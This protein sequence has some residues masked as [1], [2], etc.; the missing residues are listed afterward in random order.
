MADSN[1][2]SHLPIYKAQASISAKYAPLIQRGKFIHKQVPKS[3]F[4]ERRKA[5]DRNIDLWLDGSLYPVDQ[6]S[7]KRP[8]FN[9]LKGLLEFV[10][11]GEDGLLGYVNSLQSQVSHASESASMAQISSLHNQI[12]LLNREIEAHEVRIHDI[13]S[14]EAQILSLNEKLWVED[15]QFQSLQSDLHVERIRH[16]SIEADYK[17]ATASLTQSHKTELQSVQQN[18]VRTKASLKSLSSKLDGMRKT[19]YGYRSQ[20]RQRKDLGFLSQNGGHAKAQRRLIRA[21]VGPQTVGAVQEQN[22][23]LGLSG[24]LHGDNEAQ[25]RTGKVF[26]G[27]LSQKEV[28]SML[29]SSKLTMVGNRMAQQYLD[30]IGKNICAED[31]LETC[32]RSGITQSGYGALYKTFKRAASCAGGGSR[33]RCLPPPHAVSKLRQ[34]LNAK[35]SDLIG[36]HQHIDS[37]FDVPAPTKSKSKE[38]MKITLSSKNSLFVDVEAVQRT[39]VS[40]YGITPS[41]TISIFCFIWI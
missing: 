11:D 19:P 26:A 40:L 8:K 12:M 27:L 15:T 7:G 5:G 1:L 37:S 38:P 17:L 41:G 10:G 13:P 29:E 6:R 39:I 30:K 16:A 21:I 32:D 9:S 31:I 25:I 22:A 3:S 20:V 2:Q 14:L 18:L 24:R 35:L 23:T 34:E 36:E 33:V 4:P 28:E